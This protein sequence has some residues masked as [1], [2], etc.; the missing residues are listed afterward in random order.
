MIVLQ[1]SEPS[2]LPFSNYEWRCEELYL[3]SCGCGIS[4]VTLREE[5]RLRVSGSSMMKSVVVYRRENVTKSMQ[6]MGLT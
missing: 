3:F 6:R 1:A 4:S 2:I 5:H